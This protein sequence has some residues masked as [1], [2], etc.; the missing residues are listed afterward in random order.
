MDQSSDCAFMR[1]AGHVIDSDQ[2]F[3]ELGGTMKARETAVAGL[4][5]DGSREQRSVGA[6]IK[7]L[8]HLNLSVQ[9]DVTIIKVEN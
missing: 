3:I 1:A 7:A 9:I 8:G 2:R 6:I 4:I 5:V